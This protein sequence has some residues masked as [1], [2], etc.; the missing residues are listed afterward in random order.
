MSNNTSFSV[1]S[2]AQQNQGAVTYNTDS[3]AIDFNNRLYEA[4]NDIRTKSASRDWDKKLRKERDGLMRHN[5]DPTSVKKRN[6]IKVT[7]NVLR[8]VSCRKQV[9]RC[10]IFIMVIS[11]TFS[12]EE[13][14]IL[15]KDFALRLALKLRLK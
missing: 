15:N 4:S 2:Q 1:T 12:M 11:S 7:R 9:S 8:S 5:L 10:E 13:K 3:D 14:D 6:D